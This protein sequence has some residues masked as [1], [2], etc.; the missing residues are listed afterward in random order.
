MGPP[1]NELRRHRLQGGSARLFLLALDHGLP[2]GP[3][4]GIENPS[5]LLRSLRDAPLTGVIV[6]PGTVRH[7]ASDLGPGRG[8]VVHLSGG[9][10]LGAH[11]TSKVS[12]TSVVHAVA[13]GADAVSVH[14]HFGDPAEDRMMADAGRTVDEARSLG[15]PTLIMAYPP[16][17]AGTA[18]DDPDAARHAARAA[19]E[20]GADLVQT[21]YVGPSESVQE[22]VRSCRVPLLLAGGPRLGTQ[23]AFLDSIRAGISAGVAGYAVGRNL[24]Q[25]QDPGAFALQI[26]EAIFGGAPREISVGVRP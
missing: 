24:F 3:L 15:I 9:T 5:A 18:S 4:R 25:H 19:A 23:E 16:S 1:G 12:I 6:N 22:I 13:L 20:L 17:G 11:P 2:A 10:M 14:I 8:L 26:G 21:N 7:L